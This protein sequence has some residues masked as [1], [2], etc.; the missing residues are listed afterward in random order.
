MENTI[1]RLDIIKSMY[2]RPPEEFELLDGK[3]Y[4]GWHLESESGCIMSLDEITN[5]DIER[6]YETAELPPDKP[7]FLKVDGRWMLVDEVKS[8]NNV[9]RVNG[10]I[11]S[12]SDAIC[13]EISTGLKQ[14][15]VLLPLVSNLELSRPVAEEFSRSL[16]D[17]N[18]ALADLPQQYKG[19]F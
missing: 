6:F 16:H 14:I 18:T 2:G 4:F 17:F 15:S 11:V 19:I 5:E 13:L 8:Q 7:V 12:R 9:S 10:R 3:Q 1:T